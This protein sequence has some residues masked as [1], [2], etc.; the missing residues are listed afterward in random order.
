MYDVDDAV[1]KLDG[2]IISIAGAARN[3]GEKRMVRIETV[4]RTAAS[5]LL[6]DESGEVIRPV[7]RPAPRT[8]RRPRRRGSQAAERPAVAVAEAAGE[9]PEIE[10][11]AAA[12]GRSEEQAD[13]HPPRSSMADA[14]Q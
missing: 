2:Y 8:A 10:A 9:E 4:G 7:P 5:A 11:S 1:A 6:L 12:E 3:V 13:E 14:P